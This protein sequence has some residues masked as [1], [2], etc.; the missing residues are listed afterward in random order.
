MAAKPTKSPNHDAL[1]E[2]LLYSSAREGDKETKALMNAGTK[3]A[4][5]FI[6]GVAFLAF[7]LPIYNIWEKE[8]LGRAELAQAEYSKQVQIE[9]AKANLESEKLNALS[10]VERAKG[11]AESNR[12][13]SQSIDAN[14]LRYLWVKGLSADSNSVIYVPTEANMPIMEAGSRWGG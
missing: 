12:I 5:L 6:I 11:V 1:L 13:I 9:E 2:A 7:A 8:Q 3:L 10:E 4:I 14:Y